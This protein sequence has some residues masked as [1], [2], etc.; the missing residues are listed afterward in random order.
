MSDWRSSQDLSYHS[1][2]AGHVAKDVV[3]DMAVG[4]TRAEA[5]RRL[6]QFGPN[7]LPENG[8][9]G[10]LQFLLRQFS[11]V[12]VYVL[13]AAAV[14]SLL[15]GDLLE[16]T[17]ILVIAVL[18][19][20]LG[21]VQEYRAESSLRALRSLSAPSATVL[22]EGALT[23]IPAHDVVPGDILIV[24]A[25]D[26]V[27]ADA[28]VFESSSLAASEALLTGE[29]L[30]QDKASGPVPSNANLAERSSMLYQGTL[31]SRGRGRAV[32][33]NTGAGTEM[34]RIAALVTRQVREETPLQRELS[35]VGR[36]LALATG[37][38]CLF[39]FVVGVL[40]GVAADEML[41]TA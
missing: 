10:A 25:G 9:P 6:G 26:I 20:S 31:I 36:Y 19:A 39:V 22:R 5:A 7:V 14:V 24:E 4:L 40:R 3:T 29:S 28:R 15:L 12:L 1:K 17:S 11:S 30:P 34:G 37:V 8:A 38:L 16:F 21:F 2:L 23:R 35:T 13:L 33:V 27:A 32:T 41:L 18:N